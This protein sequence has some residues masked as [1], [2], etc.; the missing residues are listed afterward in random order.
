[1]TLSAG[2]WVCVRSRAALYQQRDPRGASI[3]SLLCVSYNN[4]ILQITS[5]YMA[6]AIQIKR[7]KVSKTGASKVKVRTGLLPAVRFSSYIALTCKTTKIL[8][9]S[10]LY[11]IHYCRLDNSSRVR[12]FISVKTT[13]ANYG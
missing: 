6:L 2:L 1:M 7:R 11:W 9:N 3:C 10:T 5:D 8:I 12:Y 4:A 13:M